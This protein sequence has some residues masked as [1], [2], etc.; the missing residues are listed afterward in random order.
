MISLLVIGVLLAFS[1]IICIHELG[2]FLAARWAGIRVLAFAIGFGPA[3][4]SWR[5][6]MGWRPGSSEREYEKLHAANPGDTSISPTEYRLNAVLFGGY[7]KMLGQ[8]DINPE[9]VSDE[10]DSYQNCVVWKRMVVISA[11][12]IANLILGALLFVAVFMAGRETE[13]PWVGEPY[14]GFPAS[15]AQALN[16]GE[17]GVTE[18]GLLAGDRVLEID[19]RTALSFQD[20]ILASAMAK[21]GTPVHLTVER[22]GVAAP[23]EFEIVPEASLVIP[24]RGIGVR[25][26]RSPVL[27]EA[28]NEEQADMLAESYA[29]LGWDDVAPGMQLVRVAGDTDVRE[30]GAMLHAIR[31]SAGE[32]IEAEFSDGAER[33]VVSIEPVPEYQ[34]GLIR[35]DKT[36]F[37][38]FKHLLG[39]TPVMIVGD[40]NERG[41]AQGLIEGD[42]VA[43]IGTREFPSIPEGVAAI[44][45]RTGKFIDVVVLRREQDGEGYERVELLASV[46]DEGRIGFTP[47]DTS[48]DSLLLAR[49]PAEIHDIS[50]EAD[51]RVP[52]AHALFDQ[53]GMRIVS[54]GDE[55]VADFAELR[56]ALLDATAEAQ[57]SGL[58]GTSVTLS[59]LAADDET[60]STVAWS[61]TG[62][63][64]DRLHGLRWTANVGMGLFRP[65]QYVLQAEQPLAA[66]GMGVGETRR[67]VLTTYLTI[68]RTFQGTIDIAQLKGPVGIVHVG[69]IVAEKGLMEFL[70]LLALISVN[71]AVVNFLPLPIVDG[72]QF[73]FLLFEQVRGRPVPVAVQNATTL[74]GLVLI[75]ALFLF[76]TYNDIVGIF[77]GL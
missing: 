45:D 76:V 39:L 5:K 72:G 6:G 17:L 37:A 7:V 68:V 66:I 64:L 53:P 71:L 15:T 2:H 65:E 51:A 54:V 31:R 62:E 70:F 22:D 8:E 16:A 56:A 61:L 46:S 60:P 77:N 28:E 48:A 40:T 74:A 32:P 57:R 20:L 30:P 38:L 47:D 19:G 10:P 14:P 29:T 24:M 11:G 23:L 34:T 33:A 67:W 44:R 21:R 41:A 27:F 35:W 73:L 69:T 25:P 9:A 52:A 55:P 3:L 63:D 42:I 58:P 1:L 36:Q 12:V 43:L 18:P 59:V 4:F 26:A 75:G 13:P 50:G 49:T